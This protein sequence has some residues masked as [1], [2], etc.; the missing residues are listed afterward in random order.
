LCELQTGS[1]G[2]N[3]HARS[4]FWIGSYGS[5][6]PSRLSIVGTLQKIQ[7]LL[8]PGRVCALPTNY[9]GAILYFPPSIG[10]SAVKVSKNYQE[11][12]KNVKP[13]GTGTN[14][15][16]LAANSSPT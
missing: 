5:Y 14:F 8:Y 7:G 16:R 1:E 13:T 9:F 4:V 6:Q 3:K 10:V 11:P 12:S 15:I 2:R